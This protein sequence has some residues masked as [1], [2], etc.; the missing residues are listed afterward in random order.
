[1]TAAHCGSV[2]APGLG[3][4]ASCAIGEAKGTL[5]KQMFARGVSSRLKQRFA[6]DIGS[7]AM[8][9]LLRPGTIGVEAGKKVREILVIGLRQQCAEAPKEV[10]EHIAGLRAASN[11]LFVCVRDDDMDDQA[12]AESDR[13]ADATGEQCLF[14]LRRVEPA[15]AG[16]Q[17][18]AQATILTSEWQPAGH[19]KLSLNG[20]DLDEVWR[21]L[22]AQVILGD[23]DGSDLEQKIALHRR[24]IELQEEIAKLE[25]DHH[26]AKNAQKRNE[27]FAKLRAD[28]A[29][30][31]KLR[32]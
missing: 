2:S 3:L 26:R 25:G 11:I 8:L 27:I 4:P 7:I 29:E 12:D 16:H 17:G 22:C 18:Q 14:A 21:S 20:T 5:P 31:E 24:A 10:M 15:K 13:K 30:L 19:A 1:M 28:R 6:N 23:E 32:A 9:A